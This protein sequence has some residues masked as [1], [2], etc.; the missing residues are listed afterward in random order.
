MSRNANNW[1]SRKKHPEV[2]IPTLPSIPRLEETAPVLTVDQANEGDFRY[3]LE[4]PDVEQYIRQFV[5]GEFGPIELPPV[6]PGFRYATV[7]SV[8]IRVGG[9]PVGRYRELMAVCEDT[10]ELEEDW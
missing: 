9:E 2:Q 6:P 8:T 3:F 7:V 10:N 5:P 4:H 1:G